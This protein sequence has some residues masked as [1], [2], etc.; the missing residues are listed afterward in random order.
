MRPAEHKEVAVAYAGVLDRGNGDLLV[1]PAGYRDHMVHF[2]DETS[3]KEPHQICS[4]QAG[5]V[6]RVLGEL[7]ARVRAHAKRVEGTI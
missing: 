3:A 6:G 4:E 1:R 5:D 2:Y 7:L